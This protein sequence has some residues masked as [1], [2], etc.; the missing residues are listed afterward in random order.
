MNKP[1][2]QLR[3]VV[4]EDAPAARCKNCEH[5]GGR[6]FR[7]N[8]THGR[9][10]KFD[11]PTLPN[12]G[13]HCT[14]FL[15]IASPS[16]AQEPP[17]VRDWTEDAAH[18]NGRYQNKCANCGSLFIGHKRR[19]WC[20]VCA[21]TQEPPW[22]RAALKLAS[23]VVH[24]SVCERVIEAACREY[25]AALA[26]ENERLQSMNKALL[27][28]LSQSNKER[29]KWRAARDEC[30]RQFQVKVEEIASLTAERDKLQAALEFYADPD[31]YFGIAFLPDPPCGAFAED[32]EELSGVLS[33]PDGQTW[34]KPGKL[35]RA[36]LSPAQK[37][38]V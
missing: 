21:T 15:P 16:S 7:E 23:P 36:A 33:H 26:Q 4:R 12:Y 18:E 10:A 31:N 13:E 34:V 2:I 25:A 11:M 30:E 19:V 8:A 27:A 20:R 5:W 17:N 3:A 38:E 32:F 6:E 35:A 1:N 14:G 28:D 29:D 24:Y 9:C 37:E 22:Y